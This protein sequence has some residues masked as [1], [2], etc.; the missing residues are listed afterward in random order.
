MCQTGVPCDEP[1]A[2]VTFLVI[3]KG[4]S[5]RVTTDAKGRYRIRLAPG[6]YVISRNNWGLG[7]V[8]PA[9]AVVDRTPN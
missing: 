9:S 8:K 5:H 6:R 1:A 2:N 7:D 4:H 3:R